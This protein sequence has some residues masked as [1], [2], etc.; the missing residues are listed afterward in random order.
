MAFEAD[1][2]EAWPYA[3]GAMSVVSFF[4]WMANYRRYRQVHDVPTSKIASAAQGYVE[5]FGRA[6]LVPEST[7]KAPISNQPCCWFSYCIESK[8]SDDKWKTVESGESVEH[9]R[10]IDDTGE[11]VIAPDGAEILYTQY[12]CWTE[13]NRRY[14]EELLL[15][16]RHLYALG[17]LRTTNAASLEH[18][19]SKAVGHLLAAWKK[20]GKTLLERFDSD[21]S[22]KLD[23]SEWEAARLAAQRE[24]RKKHSDRRSIEGV[25]FLSKPADG[26]VFIIAGELPERIGRRF[27]LWSGVH[28]IF[29]FGA[30]IASFVLFGSAPPAPAS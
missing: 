6:A 1:T 17:E 15:P 28:L 5:F 27:A 10:L 29:F 14:T 8:T 2:P 16:E 20:D 22:G 19:E 30:G 11:C 21:R 4:A 26:R 12:K 18:E 7:L 25:H 13:G 24:V 23:L 9:F 3:L